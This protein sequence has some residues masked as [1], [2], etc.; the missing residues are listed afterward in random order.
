MTR[1]V[2]I[3][4]NELRRRVYELESENLELKAPDRERQAL[5]QNATVG[6]AIAVII[7]GAVMYGLGYSQ[8]DLVIGAAA[9][10]AVAFAGSIV[11]P[12][13]ELMIDEPAAAPEPEIV[14]TELPEQVDVTMRPATVMTLL[15][16][17]GVNRMAAH[18]AL[19]YADRSSQRVIVNARGVRNETSSADSITRWGISH[20]RGGKLSK[21]MFDLQLT[22]KFSG[23]MTALNA[24]GFAELRKALAGDSPAPTTFPDPTVPQR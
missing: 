11:W 18:H 6:T 12:M 23:E 13:P 22:D 5:Y 14:A 1:E 20:A 9:C 19:A 15:G 10:G 16:F 8:L 17:T 21:L 24:D 2:Y 4:M 3:E 7:D